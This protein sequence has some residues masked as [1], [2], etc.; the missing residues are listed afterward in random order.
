MPYDQD[1][2]KAVK[3]PAESKLKLI[4]FDIADIYFP[5]FVIQINFDVF[6]LRNRQ[7]KTF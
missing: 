4:N 2:L 3:P 6:P 1:P 5:L 7:F